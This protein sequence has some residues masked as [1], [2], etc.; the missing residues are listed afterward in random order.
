MN[1]PA[2][3]K[4][5]GREEPALVARAP[6]P[7]WKKKAVREILSPFGVEMNAAPR[8]LGFHRGLRARLAVVEFLKREGARFDRLLPCL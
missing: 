1:P 2:P 4:P 3:A 7:G 5:M 6:D 8:V